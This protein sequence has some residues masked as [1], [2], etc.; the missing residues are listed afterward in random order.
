MARTKRHPVP[1][2]GGDT[3]VDA[4]NANQ[5]RIVLTGYRGCGRRVFAKF[6]DAIEL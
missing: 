3:L 5:D 1:E 2:H 4:T 6:K